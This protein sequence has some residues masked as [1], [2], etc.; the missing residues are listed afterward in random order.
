MEFV[1]IASV[2]DDDKADNGNS[3]ATDI[4]AKCLVS[5]IKF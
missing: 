1:I 5:G 3:T 2:A 4:F